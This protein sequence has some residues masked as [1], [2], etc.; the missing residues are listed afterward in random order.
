MPAYKYIS[1]KSQYSESANIV[2]EKNEFNEPIRS[3]AIGEI[4]DL[5][6]QEANE[7][8]KFAYLEKVSSS[9]AQSEKEN[10]V[11]GADVSSKKVKA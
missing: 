4:A 5:T 8:E 3:I 11:L 9:N 10:N 2:L 6:E 7:I 1:N